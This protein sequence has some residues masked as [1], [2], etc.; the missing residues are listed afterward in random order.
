MASVSKTVSARPVSS[1]Q[2]GRNLWA[3]VRRSW[4]AYAL[5]SPLFILLVIFMYYPPI[6][7]LIRSFYQWSP[8]KDAVFVGLDNFVAYLT[9][10]ETAREFA[11]IFKILVLGWCVDVI[12]PFIMA[13][14]I[15]SV[16]SAAAKRLYRTLVSIP[17]IAP[18]IVVVLLWR[19]LYDPNLGPINAILDAFGLNALRHNWLGDP[20][21]ALYAIIGIGFPWM[22]GIGTLIY[23]GGLG[24]I[25]DSV[26]DAALLDGCVGLRRIIRIDIPLMRGQIRLLTIL[27]VVAA[28]TAFDRI[29]VL[30][31]G[32]PGF[33]TMVPA[34]SMYK[35][36]FISQQF[37]IASAIGLLIFLMAGGLTTLI[38]KFMRSNFD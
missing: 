6:L 7:G 27:S 29:L 25:S 8:G 16:R 12:A 31:N 28:V 37:G 32:G 3:E 15:F 34:L 5:L 36:A 24:N 19:H 14:M 30:T 18:G 33:A 38:N 22:A 10:P 23:L 1:T 26:F 2:Q 13:E 9:Y 20:N 35:R 21:I 4:Q 17:M 11:N